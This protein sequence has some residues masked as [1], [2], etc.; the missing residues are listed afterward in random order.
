EAPLELLTRDVVVL[1]EKPGGGYGCAGLAVV[2]GSQ[3]QPQDPRLG[4][5]FE[6]AAHE[7]LQPKNLTPTFSPSEL[8]FVLPRPAALLE[9]WVEL[10]VLA[11]IAW[12]RVQVCP[13]CQ[14]L[15]SFRVGCQA[16]GSARLAADQ[17]IHHFAC[18]HVGF[19]ADFTKGDQLICP[20]C[21]TR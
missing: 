14:G 7:L 17:L 9:Q 12:D 11:R 1:V 21:R 8:A 16:C 19:V 2:E 20:K 4:G 5:R 15:P 6:G 10:G 13:R 18:A 3:A